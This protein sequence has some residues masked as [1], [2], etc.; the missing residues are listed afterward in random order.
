MIIGTVITS[1][2]SF[3]WLVIAKTAFVWGPLLA[4]YL[5]FSLW[6]HFVTDRF[7]LG[8]KWTLFEV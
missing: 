2:L 8:M 6:H 1:I 4:L 5:G 3:V 7:I